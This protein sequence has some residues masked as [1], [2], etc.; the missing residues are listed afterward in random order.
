MDSVGGALEN[1]PMDLL[2]AAL[3]ATVFVMAGVVKGISGMGL[4]TVAMSLL[5]I[6]LAPTEAA[7]LLILPSLATNVAQC[8]G[9]HLRAL[10]KRLW[11]TWL[12]LVLACIFSPG[13]S[14]ATATSKAQMFLGVV[15]ML[16]GVW[17]L[18][19]K[20]VPRVPNQ[21]AWAGV[22]PGAITGFITAAT[23]VF[24]IPMV[25]YLQILRLEKDAMI[26]AL[27][28]CFTVATVALAIRLRAADAF[29]VSASTVLALSM[30]LAGIWV[31]S[32]LRSKLS[33]PMFQR[34]LFVVFIGL[35]GVNLW[36]SI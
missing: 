10:T 29:V 13:P 14:V 2:R 34:I 27:G 6:F 28:L 16:Y 32:R 25:P 4:P 23:A 3:I 17:G 35:G 8:T 20:A 30:A 15:L 22:V 11:P 1:R 9:P 21:P 31:G 24:V 26:Q 36:R 33:Q 12:G 19:Q 18:S 7:A 5:G